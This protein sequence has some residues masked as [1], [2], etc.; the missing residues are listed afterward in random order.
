MI[1]FRAALI[2]LAA[3][4][5]PVAA[6]AFDPAAMTPAE[7]AALRA[8]IRA[9]LLENPEVMVEVFAALDARR[10][11]AEAADDASRIAA[12][13]GALYDDPASWVGGNPAGDVTIVEFIDYRCGY[14]RR[15]H[16]EMAAL[17]AEDNNIRVI[18]KEFPILGPD[19]VASS[20]FA[21]AVLNTAG[22]EAYGRANAALI[23]L[24]PPATPEVLAGLAVELGLDPGAI[25]TAMEAPE[26]TAVIER[27]RALATRLGISGTPSFVIGD[28]VLRGFLPRDAMAEI[29][30]DARSGG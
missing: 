26:V 25:L 1:P 21:I 28:I 5:F 24:A 8:E 16:P 10:A 11:A 20:R 27:N 29:V 17:L 18:V 12:E 2:P 4:I 7:R 14:C 3:L 6:A 30:A 23:A 22:P 15:A 19:S 13:A 9:Y